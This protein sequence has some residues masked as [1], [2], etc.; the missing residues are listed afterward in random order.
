MKFLAIVGEARRSGALR[1]VTSLRTRVS[2]LF[3]P[4]C[5]PA[6]LPSLDG[7]LWRN[8]RSVLLSHSLARRRRRAFA[9][10]LARSGA[11]RPHGSKSEASSARSVHARVPRTDRDR[12][13]CARGVCAIKEVSRGGRRALCECEE[14]T[15]R[16]ARTSR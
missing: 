12:T 8:A 3:R 7:G 14:N 15:R 1:T 6:L 5:P 4:T 16:D 2:R 11:L 13:W 10:E 9:S